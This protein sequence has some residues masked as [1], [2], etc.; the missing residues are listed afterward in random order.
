MRFTGQ[1]LAAVNQEGL[2]SYAKAMKPFIVISAQYDMSTDTYE[3][4]IYDPFG[5]CLPILEYD[6]QIPEYKFAVTRH[7][8]YTFALVK[9]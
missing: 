2:H 7:E 9:S 1:F 8:W 4:V 5:E 6:A 3:Q